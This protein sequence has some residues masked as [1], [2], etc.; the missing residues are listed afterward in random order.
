MNHQIFERI[1]RFRVFLGA[2]L[3]ECLLNTPHPPH[4]RVDAMHSAD[5]DTRAVESGRYAAA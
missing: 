2:C 5:V 1:L 4:M 3:L